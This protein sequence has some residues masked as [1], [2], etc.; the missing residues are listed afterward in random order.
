M[1]IV[2]GEWAELGQTTLGTDFLSK[3][4]EIDGTKVNLQLWDTGLLFLFNLPI[5]NFKLKTKF[6]L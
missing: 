4:V 3:E 6:N 1:C 5:Q 2:K